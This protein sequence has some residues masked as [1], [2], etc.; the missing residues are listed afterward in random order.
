MSSPIEAYQLTLLAMVEPM[1]KFLGPQGLAYFQGISDA[2]RGE[3]CAANLSL[4]GGHGMRVRNMMREKGIMVEI[5]LTSNASILGVSGLEHPF[6]LYRR[7][8]IPLNLNTDDEGVSRSN[9]TNELVRAVRTYNLHY[10]DLKEFA[11]NSIEYSFLPGQ[12][13]YRNRDY[14]KLIKG[15]DGVRKPQWSPSISAQGAMRQSDKLRV[16]VRLERAWAQFER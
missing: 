9:L 12:S 3:L 10:S 11:R 7:A 16:Q 1:C 14:R 4:H 6:L 13:L 5:C 8:G 15:F 2:G